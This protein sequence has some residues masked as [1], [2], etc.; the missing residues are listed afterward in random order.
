MN[1][2][3]RH[4]TK[5]RGKSA[6]LLDVF[7]ETFGEDAGPRLVEAVSGASRD[8][9][10]ALAATYQEYRRTFSV[11]L[12]K[13]YEIRPYIG[14]GYLYFGAPRRTWN[15]PV[16]SVYG[17]RR[18]IGLL[19]RHVLYGHSVALES[20]LL[21]MLEPL[22]REG[23]DLGLSKDHPYQRAILKE[24][25]QRAARS[26]DDVAKFCSLLA[27]IAPLIEAGL[28]ILLEPPEDTQDEDGTEYPAWTD[29]GWRF[30]TDFADP[31]RRDEQEMA[32]AIGLTRVMLKL[33]ELVLEGEFLHYIPR[34][35]DFSDV[36]PGILEGRRSPFQ[37][38]TNE[39]D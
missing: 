10:E 25:D 22:F 33:K 26:R 18:T 6:T 3:G 35:L 21:W 17:R 11:P 30:A 1:R 14:S 28:V 2:V 12:K 19:H 4:A 7:R 29:H 15:N 39:K 23:W 9:L 32:I 37:G 34:R 27:E 36:P 38:R 5:R 13:D 31:Y 8:Q 20:P 16:A 24:R